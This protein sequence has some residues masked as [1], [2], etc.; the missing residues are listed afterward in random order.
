MINGETVDDEDNNNILYIVIGAAAGAIIVIAVLLLCI[1]CYC[2][3]RRHSKSKNITDI[4]LLYTKSTESVDIKK[5][6]PLS[7]EP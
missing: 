3:R 5:T 4:S 7:D 2:V 6:N 1:I